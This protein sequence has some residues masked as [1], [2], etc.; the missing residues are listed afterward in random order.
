MEGDHR[1]EVEPLLWTPCQRTR[2]F[3]PTLLD[4]LWIH[5]CDLRKAI[6]STWTH[7]ISLYSEVPVMVLPIQS[8]QQEVDPTVQGLVGMGRFLLAIGTLTLV[9]V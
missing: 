8:A 4:R 7:L 9:D 3:L 1:Q 6:V 2:E 5:V